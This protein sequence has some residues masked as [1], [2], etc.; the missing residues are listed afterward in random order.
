MKYPI[1]IPI[2]FYYFCVLHEKVYDFTHIY[3]PICFY[4]FRIALAK[5]RE[6]EE[7]YIPI[8]FYYFLIFFSLWCVIAIIYI[9]ICFYYFDFATAGVLTELEFTF[10]YV[11]IISYEMKTNLIHLT[12]F[13]FQYVSIISDYDVSDLERKLLN[14]HSNMFL[15]FQIR[16]L[17]T[18]LGGT[19][20]HSNMFLL[21]L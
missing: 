12:E 14:L 15:L 19:H 6:R 11:S 16:Y 20:L 7:I 10:Q 2:C 17:G 4:Y 13:T 5:K 8:C 21:F 3:I 9:P 18:M 1:Y